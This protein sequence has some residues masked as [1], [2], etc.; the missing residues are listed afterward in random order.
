M[1]LLKE[2]PEPIVPVQAIAESGRRAIPDRYVKPPSERPSS[3]ES[4]TS[5]FGQEQKQ[6]LNI[7]LVDLGGLSGSGITECRAATIKAVSDACREWGFFQVVNHG[8]SLDL[9]A[10]MKTVW[11]DFFFRLPVEEKL[12]LANSPRTYEGY[13]SR[14]GVQKG[15]ILDWGDYYFLHVLPESIKN[16]SKWPAHPSSCRY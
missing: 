3:L 11:R 15:A 12:K 13:G 2:W 5:W 4:L 14:V 8:V 10:T 16:Y 7:P 6:E 1:D 9:V